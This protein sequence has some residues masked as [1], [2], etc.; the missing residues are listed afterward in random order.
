[1]RGY[2]NIPLTRYEISAKVNG[3]FLNLKYNRRSVTLFGMSPEETSEA[4]SLLFASAGAKAESVAP[5][6]GSRDAV[7]V[8][9][10]LK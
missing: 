3:K 4:A 9:L 5:Q 8:N 2:V 6:S 7:S 1:M 10:A